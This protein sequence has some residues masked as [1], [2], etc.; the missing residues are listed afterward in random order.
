MAIGLS[1]QAFTNEGDAVLIQNPVYYP[2]SGTVNAA[3]RKLVVNTL[4]WQNGRYCIDFD[5]FETQVRE[6]KVKLF[7]LCNPHNP[8]GTSWSKEELLRL[9]EICLK[10]NVIV[11][12]DEIHSDFV[13]QP[14]THTMFASLSP[15]LEHCTITCTSPTKSFNLA[16]L[17]VSNIFI[18]NESLRSLF[19]TALDAVGYSQPNTLGLTACQAAYTKGEDWL[20]QVKAYIQKNMERSVQFLKESNLPLEVSQPEATYL[21]WINCKDLGLEDKELNHIITRE[22]KLWL[23]AGRIF[24]KEGLYFERINVAT[25]WA[26]LKE[27]LERFT[28]TLKKHYS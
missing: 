1:I 13:W 3:K 22:A 28:Q 4:L 6:N 14:H 17:Q 7:L 23:D 25:S 15:E 2:F 5:A 16:G 18:Q 20:L 9:G 27:G 11:L 12:S 21:L 10:Y 24:G 19:Q 26:Y 8:G